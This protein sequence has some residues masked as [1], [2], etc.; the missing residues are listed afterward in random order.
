MWMPD[1]VALEIVTHGLLG[2][3]LEVPLIALHT[4][5]VAGSKPAAPMS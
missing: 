3:L 5:E 1:E 4:L 2:R